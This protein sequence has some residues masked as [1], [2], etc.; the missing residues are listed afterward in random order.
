MVNLGSDAGVRTSAL[1]TDMSTPLGRTIGNG[2]E[3]TESVEVLAGG[4][5]ADVVEPTVELARE[6]LAGAGVT[7]VD[8]ADALADGRAMDM[9]RRMITAQ[10]GDVDAVMPEAPHVEEVRA[11]R[12]GILTRVDAL[13]FGIAGW[14]LGA[15]RA[16]KE[17]PVQVSAGVTLHK[18]LGDTVKAGEV[19]AT[20]HTETESR[21]PR[22]L[23]ALDEACGGAGA[24]EIGDAPVERRIVLDRIEA[25]I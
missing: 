24:I 2:L 17:D 13:G 5:P 7:G 16:R 25:A 15:G 23:A 11:D 1:L 10:G 6:M 12:D 22:G 18:T 8:P 21:M 19:I 14:R 3:V 20:L 4:G 9:W